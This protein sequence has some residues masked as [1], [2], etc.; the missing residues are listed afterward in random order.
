ML[1]WL[2]H[3]SF[4]I[5]TS[6]EAWLTDPFAPSVGYPIPK[7]APTVVSMSHDHYDHADESWLDPAVPRVRDGASWEGEDLKLFPV[8][9]FHDQTGGA[10][11]GTNFIYIGETQDLRI[12][13]LGDLG[14]VLQE[15]HV[16]K[17]GKVDILLLP[18]GGTY[19][20]GPCEAWQVVEALGPSVVIPMHYQTEH[21]TFSLLSLQEFLQEKPHLW[22]VEE[23]SNLEFGKKLAEGR[24]VVLKYS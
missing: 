21:L 4:L 20:I 17:I 14:H 24:I 18:V 1:R 2:G 16:K 3:S 10:E 12:V 11:R 23:K 13:H 19:T 8:A 6:R 5:E 7:V 22:T 9:S 15:E